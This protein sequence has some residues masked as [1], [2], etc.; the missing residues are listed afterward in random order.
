MPYKILILDDQKDYLRSLT[1]A[2]SGYFEVVSSTEISA[3]KTAID[4]DTK[5]ILV[6]ICLSETDYNNRDGLTFISEARKNHPQMPILAI[7]GIQ[8]SGVYDQSIKAG[9]NKFIKKPINI[10]ELKNL[11]NDITRQ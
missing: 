5:A 1:L 9:A 11:L 3:A 7:S 6:D 2:L 8:D 10:N 4:S